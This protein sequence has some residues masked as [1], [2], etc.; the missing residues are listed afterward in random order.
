M[1]KRII[2]TLLALC[3]CI[4]FTGCGGEK[5]AAVHSFYGMRRGEKSGGAQERRETGASNQKGRSCSGAGKRKS[6][7]SVFFLG[8]HYPQGSAGYS[9]KDRRRFV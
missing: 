3:L 4:P 2:F 7:G 6:A 5:K 1:L 8:R 9:A